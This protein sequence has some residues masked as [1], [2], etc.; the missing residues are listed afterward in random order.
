M[1]RACASSAPRLPTTYRTDLARAARA[2][3]SEVRGHAAAFDAAR[4]N[5][6]DPSTYWATDD[7]VTSAAVELSW[8]Q[9]VT[10]S[11]VVLQEAIALGQR[12]QHWTAEAYVGGAWTAIGEGTTIGHKRIARV[13]PTETTRLRITITQSRACPVISSISVYR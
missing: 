6:G 10:F 13:T 1:P 2:T 7:R 3:A 5:D 8:P 11:R 12:V 9:P 4:V